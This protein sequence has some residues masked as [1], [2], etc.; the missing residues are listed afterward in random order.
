M[1][2]PSAYLT[3]IN[4][5]RRIKAITGCTRTVSIKLSFSIIR[6][7]EE[8]K[9]HRRYLNTSKDIFRLTATRCMIILMEEKKFGRY[10]V[11]HMRAVSSRKRWIMTKPLPNMC[12]V[13]YKNFMR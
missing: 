1:K 3:K 8:E 11:W 12:L 4:R 6:K 2:P 13:K 10:T 5:E 9:G 7:A